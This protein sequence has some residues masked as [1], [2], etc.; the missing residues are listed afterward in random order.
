MKLIH[1]TGGVLEVRDVGPV[2]FRVRAGVA[3]IKRNGW[4]ILE[5]GAAREVLRELLALGIYAGGRV[6]G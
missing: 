1:S 3:P 6:E 5:D 2:I 4:E